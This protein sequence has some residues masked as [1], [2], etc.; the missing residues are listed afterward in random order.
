MSDE[1]F[2]HVIITE[3]DL[4]SGSAVVLARLSSAEAEHIRIQRVN[5]LLGA[6]SQLVKALAEHTR[7]ALVDHRGSHG[8]NDLHAATKTLYHALEDYAFELRNLSGDFRDV[9][10]RASSLA[11]QPH[12]V[13]RTEVG[14]HVTGHR[15]RSA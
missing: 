3:A 15:L 7:Y 4:H 9:A 14:N 5:G 1:L 6:A 13:A 12:S 10:D 8:S 11:R 2:R